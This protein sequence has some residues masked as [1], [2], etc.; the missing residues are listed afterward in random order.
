MNT[1]FAGSVKWKAW[2]RQKHKCACCGAELRT[3]AGEEQTF[4]VH[5]IIPLEEKND[6]TNENCVILC[7]ISP[8]NCHLRAGH[9]GDE[10]SKPCG[11]SMEELPYF[12]G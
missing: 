4:F 1:G 10:K 5:P 8:N 6:I 2:N 3:F 7:A 12:R 11:I 9:R